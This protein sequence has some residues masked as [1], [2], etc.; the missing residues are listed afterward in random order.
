MAEAPSAQVSEAL[1]YFPGCR[2]LILPSQPKPGCRP[3]AQ[4][5]RLGLR[6]VLYCHD[7]RQHGKT[8]RRP[9]ATENLP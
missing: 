6:N 5:R 3:A 4:T 2:R 9:R 1:P 7:G 8:P